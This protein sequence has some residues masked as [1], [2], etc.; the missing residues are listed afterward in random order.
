MIFIKRTSESGAV[1]LLQQSFRVDK[2]WPNRAVRAEVDLDKDEI[3]FCRL[4][5]S[6]P[7]DQPVLRKV[8]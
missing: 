7:E 8:K 5:K 6:N 1:S 3:R 4:R 2:Y